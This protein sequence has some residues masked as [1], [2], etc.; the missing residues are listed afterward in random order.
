M[1]SPTVSIRDARSADVEQ[2]VTLWKEMMDFNGE[3]E[4]RF[5]RSA[6]GHQVYAE[7][8]VEKVLPSDFS[9]VM[10]AADEAS[11][12]GY[13]VVH[14]R[15]RLPILAGDRRQGFI[16]AMVVAASSRRQGIATALLDAAEQWC[17]Q[18]GLARVELYTALK[19]EPSRSFW[20]SQGYLPYVE[21]RGKDL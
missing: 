4:P 8:L 10:V 19:S 9:C 21:T 13:V 17:G 5:A 1:N 16:T 2:I 18:R 7:Y 15:T 3:F 20:K 6:D 12:L 11:V 14:E